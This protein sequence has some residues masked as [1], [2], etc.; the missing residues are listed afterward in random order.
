MGVIGADS[1]SSSLL[2]V[3]VDKLLGICI[4]IRANINITAFRNVLQLS[5]ESVILW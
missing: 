3:D 5:Q 4:E 1:T 2:F